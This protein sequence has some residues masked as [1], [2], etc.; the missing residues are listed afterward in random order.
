M[1][2]TTKFGVAGFRVLP[3]DLAAAVHAA[4]PLSPTAMSEQAEVKYNEYKT[5]V[6]HARTREKRATHNKHIL[7]DR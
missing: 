5:K 6:T 2:V 7:T 1:S 4:A 3:K